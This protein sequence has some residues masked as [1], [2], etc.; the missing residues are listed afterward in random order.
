MRAEEER[1]PDILFSVVPRAQGA[2]AAA[3]VWADDCDV[4]II[5]VDLAQADELALLSRVV[6]MRGA[7]RPVIATAASG[8]VDDVRRL[9]RLGISDFLPQP[10]AHGDLEH[11]LRSIG[12]R[13]SQDE[14]MA[15]RGAV[16]V[17]ARA[18]GG[19]GATTLAT[20]FAYAMNARAPKRKVA[21]LDLDLQRGAAGL[22]LNVPAD[23]GVVSCLE[24]FPEIEPGLIESVANKHESGID[25]FAATA[26]HWPLDDYSPHAIGQMLDVMRRVY[27]WIVVDAPPV[28]TRWQHTLLERTDVAAVVTHKTVA[29]LRQTRALIGALEGALTSDQIVT[30]C[31]RAQ[32]GWLSRGIATNDANLALGRAFDCTIPADDALVSEASDL[33]VPVSRVK[34]GSK[35]EKATNALADEIEKRLTMRRLDPHAGASGALTMPTPRQDWTHDA[36]VAV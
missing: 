27:D 7:R 35:F 32:S 21:L 10:I 17:F 5:D 25:V 36:R 31:N 20:H 6:E 11:A 13:L 1:L 3:S 12:S 23:V 19:A 33:G 22:H 4:L 2:T 30:V 28:W 16:A 18:A 29:G 34:K 8:A 24:R 9:M 15:K 26:N 14:A